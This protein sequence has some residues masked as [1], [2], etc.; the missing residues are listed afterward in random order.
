MRRAAVLLA[1]LGL[2]A[3]E[4]RCAPMPGDGRWD[5]C[6]QRACGDPCTA[7]RPGARD[8]VEPAVVKACDPF[9]Q[10]VPA[11]DGLCA[12]T[13]GPCAASPCG[14]PCAIEAACRHAVPPC[15]VPDVAGTCDRDGACQP[16][17]AGPGACAPP[18]PEF[19]CRG[20]ACGESCGYCPPGQDWASCPV[21]TFAATACDAQLRCVTAG[22]F[23]C[24]P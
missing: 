18:L 19:G 12:A 23:T 3:T 10:C 24:S 22:T 11:R 7:C 17:L 8:C 5:P 21:P 16:G 15:M 13:A 6:A 20:R 1:L 14:E 9:G 2:A 4:G